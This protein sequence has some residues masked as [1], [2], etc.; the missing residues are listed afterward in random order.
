MP[1]PTLVR[2]YARTDRGSARTM[3]RLEDSPVLA[4][5]WLIPKDA[6]PETAKKIM[7]EKGQEWI[8]SMEAAPNFYAPITAPKLAVGEALEEEFRGS[9]WQVVAVARFKRIRPGFAT[10]DL[11]LQQRELAR[12]Y[13]IDTS[14]VQTF[15]SHGPTGLYHRDGIQVHRPGWHEDSRGVSLPGRVIDE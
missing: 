10:L 9:H 11:V 4:G 12:Q 1:T 7:A 3:V 8:E 13:G 2:G 14:T 15:D 6:T 5:T